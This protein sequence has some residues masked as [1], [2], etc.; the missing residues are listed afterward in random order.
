MG[1]IGF[2][3]LEALV[4][5]LAVCCLFYG[6]LCAGQ[7]RFSRK[8]VLLAL[9]GVTVTAFYAF[10]EYRLLPS[11]L[12]ASKL[13]EWKLPLR[14]LPPK[15]G[16]SLS[17]EQRAFPA[18]LARQA[19]TDYGKLIEYVDRSGNRVRFLPTD[20]D[21]QN[22][23]ETIARTDEL[24]TRN[25]LLSTAWRRWLT[26]TIAILLLGFLIGRTESPSARPDA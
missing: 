15:W 16:E 13:V 22:R 14:E 24:D 2:P 1:A 10:I 19:Y 6:A 11:M 21:I 20:E 18:I 23:A 17:S 26:T 4:Y 8:A 5:A 9:F 12:E 3:P 25:E 7:R